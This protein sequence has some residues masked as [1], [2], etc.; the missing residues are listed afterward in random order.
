MKNH[1]YRAA[2][3]ALACSANIA[4]A[5]DYIGLTYNLTP[6]GT[7]EFS[8]V[9]NIWGGGSSITYALD[10]TMDSSNNAASG[11]V[12]MVC[13]LS[14]SLGDQFVTKYGFTNDV[15]ASSYTN[16]EFDYYWASS[17]PSTNVGGF[18]GLLYGHIDQ[19]YTTSNSTIVA[20]SFNV[21]GLNPG[22][23][24][25]VHVVI[26]V[27]INVQGIVDGIYLKMDT[28]NWS[29]PQSGTV[30][31]W[32]DNIKLTGLKPAPA[33]PTIALQKAVP[34]LRIWASALNN[35]YQRDE[36]V[37]VNNDH[38]WYGSTPRTY[39]FTL[40][41]F[42]DQTH[43]NF[44][45]HM[46]LIPLSGM[47]STDINPPGP[48]NAWEDYHASNIVEVAVINAGNGTTTGRFMVKTNSS[49]SDGDMRAAGTLG[50]VTN[51]AGALGTWTVTFTDNTH[52]TLTAPGGSNT[53]SFLIP[54]DVTLFSGDLAVY[55]G[56]DPNS[57][58]DTG[59]SATF[60]HIQITGT[61]PIND[62]LTSLDSTTWQ[63]ISMDQV[64]T[65]FVPG[66]SA[67]WISWPQQAGFSL[68]TNVNLAVPAGWGDIGLA[69]QNIWAL[70]E[71]LVPNTN[72]VSGTKEF[73]G[74]KYP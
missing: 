73:F 43:V 4:L 1:L 12:Q 5:Q 74:L 14:P 64:G 27:P 8:L 66:D 61:D 42:P 3:L 7:N 48:I 35:D 62:T 56:V 55:F 53:V 60:S 21:Y 65:V 69:Q 17:S 46:F 19:G 44:Q 70:T 32:V 6:D 13:M 24:K 67:Y 22:V 49:N 28:A 34:G 54:E 11:S 38:G 29:N 39:S 68:N 18:R 15:Y 45:A 31:C 36:I 72:L 10:P 25:W 33:R 47:L 9:G 51:A 57:T 26:P 50:V 58:A 2:L 71:V 16:L 59:Q 41:S 52:A 23:N 63:V 20:S 37:T 30:T 40:A